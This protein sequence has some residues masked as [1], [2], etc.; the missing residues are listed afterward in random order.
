[1]YA[2]PGTGQALLRGAG[3]HWRAGGLAFDCVEPLRTWTLRYR[4]RL[5]A[6][7]KAAADSDAPRELFAAM[8]Q[9][10]QSGQGPAQQHPGMGCSIKW[11]D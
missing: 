2:L 8:R 3:D 4:G 11:R 9:I 7:L 10:A 6:S 5:D 1:M